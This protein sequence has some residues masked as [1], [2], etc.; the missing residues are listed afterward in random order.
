MA[1]LFLSSR[2]S[3][4][5]TQLN[6]PILLDTNKKYEAALL[7][8]HTYNSVPNITEKNNK[9]KYSS[10]RGKTWRT[11]TI[12]KGTY[13]LREINS[14]IQRE[15]LKNGDYDQDEKRYYI[16]IDYYKPTFQTLLEITSDDYMVDFDIENSLASTLGFTNEKL[17]GSGVYSSSNIIDIESVNSILV[18]CDI[19][20]GAYLNSS[21]S[22]TFYSFTQ[23]VSPGFKIIEKPSPELIFFPVV[24]RPDI[25]NIHVWL[26]DQDNN[27]IDLMGERLTINMLIREKGVDKK[28]VKK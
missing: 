5:T 13:E 12:K 4:F 3:N 23:E 21:R 27:P 8:L 28:V 22:N 14:Y 7:S 2:T 11:I 24:G 10:D 26:T 9:F 6:P 20:L 16:N 1:Y 19:V 25:Q 17:A 15:M 18:H